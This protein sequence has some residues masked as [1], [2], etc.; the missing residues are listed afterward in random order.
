MPPTAPSSWLPVFFHLNT[1]V[2][3]TGNTWVLLLLEVDT[4]WTAELRQNWGLCREAQGPQGTGPT[5][6]STHGSLK[7]Q[8]PAPLLLLP[9]DPQSRTQTR[10]EPESHEHS[11]PASPPG[12]LL[13]EAEFGRDAQPPSLG[14]SGGKP[15]ARKTQSVPRAQLE[16]LGG[17][18]TW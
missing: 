10:V 7:A 18:V 3:K 12:Q 6:I 13:S 2:K 14:A 16:P 1:P 4:R 15:A 5:P 9:E 8:S 17:A 11:F